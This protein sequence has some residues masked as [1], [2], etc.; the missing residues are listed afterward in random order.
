MVSIVCACDEASFG[1]ALVIPGVLH[2]SPTKLRG[3]HPAVSSLV[4]VT[5][6]KKWQGDGI[7]NFQS[8]SIPLVLQ[9]FDLLSRELEFT[10]ES[11]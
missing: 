3:E 11:P 10:I 5:A 6:E 7:N 1:G 4:V 8:V 2:R 9:G